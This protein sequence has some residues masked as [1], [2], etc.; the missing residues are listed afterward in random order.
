MAQARL[1]NIQVPRRPGLHKGKFLP[2]SSL[3]LS[4]SLNISANISN[5]LIEVF[6][7]VT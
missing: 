4:L 2:L 7:Q 3:S 6:H 1:Q 5:S